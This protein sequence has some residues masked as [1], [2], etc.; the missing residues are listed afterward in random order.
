[1]PNLAWFFDFHSHGACRIGAQPQPD[2]LAIRLRD[3]G[4]NEVTFHAKCH[5]G[6]SYY[7]TRIA[8]PHP[9]LHGDPLGALIAACKRQGLH[10]NAYMSFGIDGVAARAHPDWLK[11]FENGPFTSDD[12]FAY[13]C[14]FT[15]YTNQL[16]LPQL[17][18]LIDS[19]PIDGLWFD[20]MSAFRPCYC[21]TCQR[22]F[23]AQTG[24]AL[25]RDAS[26][27]RWSEYGRFR[28]MRSQALL[29]RIGRFVQSRRPGLAVA[30]NQIGSTPFPSTLPEG[31]NRLTLDFPTN[32][33]QSRQA[34]FCAAFGAGAPYAADVIPTLFVGGWGDWSM[35]P[36]SRLEQTAS[37]AWARGATLNVGDRL[38]PD[39]RLTSI[40]TRAVRHLAHVQQRLQPLLPPAEARPCPDL[41]VLHGESSHYGH[42]LRHFAMD[43]K[44]RLGA[45]RG[46]CDLLLDAGASFG[47]TP[48]YALEEHLS[49]SAWVV[50]PELESITA[51]S[52]RAL[53]RHLREGG[54]ALVIGSR[55][56]V[57][58]DTGRAPAWLEIEQDAKP[59][60]DHVYAPWTMPSAEA[61][62][63]PVLM[64]SDFLPFSAARAV[65]ELP[66]IAPMDVR[67]GQRMGWGIAPPEEKPSSHALLARLPFGAGA[68]WYLATNLAS[69]YHR[70]GDWRQALWAAMVLRKLHARRRA[71]L[72]SP[73]GQVELVAAHAE[74]ADWFTLVNHSGESMSPGG[75]WPRTW[76]PLSP[77][78]VQ[79]EVRDELGRDVRRVLV[80][81]EPLKERPALAG[82][83]SL[84]VMV[85]QPCRVVC[86]EWAARPL[87][88]VSPAASAQPNPAMVQ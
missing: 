39:A 10:V 63:E 8:T 68:A 46:L 81:G 24:A 86:V 41:L 20:T 61:G 82:V 31:I 85:N 15:E 71:W 69:E 43:G 21:P 34:S 16:M 53:Q 4:V 23:T 84:P 55:P 28:F 45:V 64:R 70:M 5:V 33:P 73:H 29:E 48:E 2:D 83:L 42:D 12:W 62:P 77:L 7:P 27:A 51:A 30:F 40:S 54:C 87:T 80:D 88:R 26:D 60:L 18:E 79:L 76:G 78:A 67:H 19:Y 36:L 58:D 13:V 50:L 9:R 59:W 32:G 44:S 22:D 38:H 14:P 65:T 3:G 11:H 52:D 56:P 6:Y 47:V 75:N 49:S 66:A 37:A 25:P 72:L 17:A 74:H 1:M 57:V 35:A